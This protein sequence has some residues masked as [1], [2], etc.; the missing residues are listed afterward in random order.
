MIIRNVTAIVAV[1]K[2]AAAAV[3]S[4]VV[5]AGVVTAGLLC[6]AMT[7]GDVC[8]RVGVQLASPTSMLAGTDAGTPLI[9]KVM[10]TLVPLFAVYVVTAVVTAWKDYFAELRTERAARRARETFLSA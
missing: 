4:L 5:V 3:V 9:A 1:V 2:M 7:I 8:A 10:V 6:S